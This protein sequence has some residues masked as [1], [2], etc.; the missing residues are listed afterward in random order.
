[1]SAHT[2]V[3]EASTLGRKTPAA[4]M[5]RRAVAYRWLVGLTSLALLTVLVVLRPPLSTVELWKF[6]LAAVVADAFFR[7]RV[8]A[9]S[10]YSFS[11]TFTIVYFL[12]AGGVAAALLEALARILSWIIAQFRRQTAQT[13]LYGLFLTGVHVYAA[14]GAA[15]LVEL[16]L[17]RPVL[18]GPALDVASPHRPIVIFGLGYLA[19][20]I[21]LGS[22]AIAARAGWQEVGS[23]VWRQAILWT[24]ISVGTSV[25]FGLILWQLTQQWFDAAIV[26]V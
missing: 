19:I 23:R 4:D 22:L 12:L 20:E 8:R 24:T 17:A 7:I 18:F 9:G 21:L 25:I 1:M 11:P 13:A 5:P 3:G 26:F 10:Y 6:L 14:I 15:V 2:E 16:I